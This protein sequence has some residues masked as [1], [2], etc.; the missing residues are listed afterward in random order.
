[1]VF[2]P[3]FATVKPTSLYSWFYSFSKVNAIEGM[4][5]FD[6]SEA[7]TTARM[8]GGCSSISTLDLYHFDTSK[9]TDMSSMF[10]RC[11]GLF[12]IYC[13]DTWSCPSSSLMFG[14]CTYLR[15]AIAFKSSNVD[16]TFANPDTGYFTRKAVKGD[17]NGDG[18]VNIADMTELIDIILGKAVMP[19]PI[20]DVTF[21]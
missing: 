11:T 7:T 9:V 17:V 13:A 4:E 14:S 1:M 15:G 6:T 12:T 3:S 21:D 16:V 2:Q 18:Q 19:G 10:Y 8:F 20:T 5:N